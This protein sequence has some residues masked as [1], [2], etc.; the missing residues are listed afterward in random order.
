MMREQLAPLSSVQQGTLFHARYDDGPDLYVGQV[1][2]SLSGELDRAALRAAAAALPGRATELRTSVGEQPSGEPVQVIAAPAHLP[3]QERDLAH[4]PA[5]RQA[6]ELTRLLAGELTGRPFDLSSPPLA[7]LLLVGL[8]PHR[9]VLALTYH[10]LI[11]DTGSACRVLSELLA[12]DAT[13]PPGTLPAQPASLDREAALMAWRTALAG[14]E[15]PTLLV[16]GAS[17]A[18]L[19]WPGRVAVC[20]PPALA[21]RLAGL[22]RRHDVAERD[23][24]LAAW[25]LVLGALTGRVDIVFGL[26]AGLPTTI[27][28]VR[29]RLDPAE[30][31]LDLVRRTHRSIARLDQY[32]WLGLADIRS[33]G[34]TSSG[35]LFDTVLVTGSA[36]LSP[37]RPAPLVTALDG[38]EYSHFPLT[39]TCQPGA[40]LLADF[41]PRALPADAARR[42]AERLLAV[43]QTM[44]AAPHQ[45]AGLVDVLLDSERAAQAQLSAPAIGPAPAT[46]P[47]MF[48]ARVRA[49]PA[50]P[51]VAH[52]GQTLSYAE[53]DARSS[54]LARVLLSMGAGPERIVAIALPPS[55]ELI[56]AILAV[57][58]AGSAYLPIDPD[59]PPGRV[60]QIL[61]D[62]RPGLVI[63]VSEVAA[64]TAGYPARRLVLDSIGQA[65]AIARQDDTTPRVPLSPGHPAYVIYTSGSTGRPKGVVVTHAGLAGLLASQLDQLGVGPGSRVLQFAS[66][67]F[68]A[69]VWEICMALLSGGTLVLPPDGRVDVLT[70]PHRAIAGQRV[71]HV[72]LPP[73]ALALLPPQ[74]LAGVRTLVA[75]GETLAGDVAAKWSGQCTMINGYGPTESTVCATMSTPLSGKATTPIGWPVTGLGVFV[76]DPWLRPVPP[77][78]TG[79]LYVA[80]SGLARGYLGRPALTGER[81]VAARTGGPGQRMYRT[82][83]LARWT[84]ADGVH[85]VGRLDDQV[86]VRGFR[87]EP[88]EIEAFL[89]AHPSVSEA[90]VV[91]DA[92]SAGDKRLLAYVTGPPDGCAPD[93]AVLGAYAR[94][95]L[96]G[97]MVPAAIEVVP[98]LPRGPSGKVDRRALV[99][100]AATAGS[101]PGARLGAPPGRRPRTPRERLLCK[102]V[103]EV[104]GTDEV[105][106]DDKL[107]DLGAGSLAAMRLAARVQVALGVRVPIRAVVEAQS[108][109]GLMGWLHGDLVR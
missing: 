48:E 43:V 47:A 29:V 86:K 96:P 93:T 81:F 32:R 20:G 67:A 75:A 100:S 8:S 1:A 33:C 97:P 60:S 88:A 95:G 44:T 26:A 63:T 87:V 57:V 106:I 62:A 94:S 10:R 15:E 35:E 65:A 104:T 11:L 22:A 7:R 6:A 9:H 13:G 77:G 4:L 23:I 34:G 36:Q 53:L 2:A 19:S 73:S 79:E 45:R 82:G 54:R 61:A 55:A 103:A 39:L 50:A 70:S 68:D 98:A 64:V 84:Q 71:S 59:Y 37:S 17:T 101:A 16:P 107:R 31:L 25:A 3:W 12:A 42:I 41:Q 21:A 69:S 46:W 89:A 30:P 14:L 90:A 83:D 27:T 40:R 76:L 80:G 58:K 92:R 108:V 109:A 91:A 78:T 66:P 18:R 99:A 49:A 28:P 56:T 38:V 51:A 72:T 85:Y 74:A 24:V 105:T 5:G 102:L 52:R